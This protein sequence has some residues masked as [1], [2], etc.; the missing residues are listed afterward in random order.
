[1][2][3]SSSFSNARGD[4]KKGHYLESE[5]VHASDQQL[6]S[7]DCG[8]YASTVI[9]LLGQALTHALHAVHRSIS[10]GST[11][12]RSESLLRSRSRRYMPKIARGHACKHLAHLSGVG[13]LSWSIF[14]STLC[15]HYHSLLRAGI[16]SLGTKVMAPF[17]QTALQTPH[18]KHFLISMILPRAWR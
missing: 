1:M 6:L 9:A 10:T 12:Q 16:S 17:S 13:H 5:P 15:P 7:G 3:S 2:L 18:P 4:T 14:I 11:L 8:N